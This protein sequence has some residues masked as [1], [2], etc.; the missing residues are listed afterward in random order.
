MNAD[1]HRN[2]TPA[3]R[4]RIAIAALLAV[5]ALGTAGFMLIE[6][7]SLIDAAYMTIITLSTIGYGE[8][9]PLDTAGRLFDIGLIAVGVATGGY[10][11]GVLA[12]I[13]IEQQFFRKIVQERRMTHEIARLR[14]HFIVCGYGRVGMNVAREVAAAGKP[15]V[16]IEQHAE[17]IEECRAAGYDAIHGDATQDTVLLRAGVERAKGVVTALDSD[18]ANLYITLSC[19][20]LRANLFIVARASEE[21]VEPKLVRA[22]ANRVLCP[23][24]LTGRRLAEMVMRP[25]MTDIVEVIDRHSHLELFLEEVTIHPDCALVNRMIGDA[26]IRVETGAAIVAVKRDDHTA[27]ANPAPQTIITADATLVAIG[28][29]DQLRRFRALAEG[30]RDATPALNVP[31]SAGEE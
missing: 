29:R 11:V 20:S 27:I 23:Y 19:R 10:A 25:E 1:F 8:V 9:H 5:F 28:T 6:H 12:E 16:V 31:T 22:G 14:D 3:G 24:A 21:S 15:F 30:R 7:W 17:L 4:L 2:L 26:T 18:A 13:F